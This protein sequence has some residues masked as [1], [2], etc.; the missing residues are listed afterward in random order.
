MS[1]TKFVPPSGQNFLALP[2][3]TAIGRY[4]IAG[5]L[6]QGSFGITYR[7]HDDQLGRDVAIKE[8]LPTSF[9]FRHDGL[10]VL[11]SST[12]AAEDFAWGR[13][14]FVEEGRILAG[15]QRAPGIVRVHDFLEANGTAYIVMELATGETLGARL[16]RQK[17]LSAAEVERILRTLL[18]GLE[19]VHAANFIHRDI[20]PDN[21]LLD[22]E[23]QPTLIDFGAARAAV[24]GRTSALTGIFTPGYAA[25]EQF[26][27]ARQG[28]FTDIYGLSAT[29]YQ[30]ITG[31]KPPSA[32]DRVLEDEYVPLTKRK[33]AGF[34]LPLL[35]GID[36]GMAIRPEARPQSIAA[37]RTSLFPGE[38]REKPIAAQVPD[39]PPRWRIAAIAGVAA[40]LVAG[41]AAGALFLFAP[42]KA[43][44]TD[45]DRQQAERNAAA[46]ANK[47][48]AEEEMERQAAAAAAEKRRTEEETQREATAEQV[49]RQ[50]AE[51]DARQQAEAA[52]R[53]QA[54]A[55]DAQRKAVEDARATVAAEEARRQAAEAEQREAARQLAEQEARQKAIAEDNARNA[56]ADAR[57]ARAEAAALD[58]KAA[59]AA[60]AALRLGPVDRQRIQVA[61][62]AQGFD[63]RGTDG[64]LG[65][66]S[67]EMIAAWQ[68]ARGFPATGFVNGAQRQRLIGDSAAAVAK[69]D[70]EQKKAAEEEAR[71]R[72]Q[73]RPD[74]TSPVV[75]PAP[76]VPDASPPAFAGRW[77]L[78]R[79]K[80]IP[81]TPQQF[82]G[83]T[84]EGNRFSYGFT[85]ANR[86]ASCSVAIG[87]D[88]S[89][90][91]NGCEAPIS[92]R[93]SGN[94]MTLSQRHPEAIC[95]FEF[96]KQ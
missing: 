60:E 15:F 82:F 54:A 26:T 72:E 42:Q 45:A 63:T 4:R 29:L 88:G 19:K 75:G 16:Q 68:T 67:R 51:A 89:F 3:G 92:G 47:S 21:I 10:T 6:G 1:D 61:L 87:P 17:R 79:S 96:Q 22:D 33:P 40:V 50:K 13:Q 78:V 12:A 7:A 64:V 25:V 65:P 48:R 95:D 37:W 76:R 20:K 38:A 27:D 36:R 59:E 80:C 32:I 30:S 62:T 2:V 31:E 52:A 58:R 84:V 8:Y 44:V 39:K 81:S 91:N 18:G 46:A 73:S 74:A 77:S 83:V 5:I 93:I 90:A 94:R 23:G 57:K 41:A 43:P 9:A 71:R 35:A 14:R 49:R 53:Q 28:P 70:A 34:A 85:F 11:P 66:H 55:D 24:A 56:E 86:S 69:F